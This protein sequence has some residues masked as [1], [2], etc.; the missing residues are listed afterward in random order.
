MSSTV[1]STMSIALAEAEKYEVLERIG[2]SSLAPRQCI[3]STNKI[4]KGVA[5]LELSAR[6]NASLME[7]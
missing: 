7:K 1:S 3:Y 2:K 6:S 5:P 4:Q